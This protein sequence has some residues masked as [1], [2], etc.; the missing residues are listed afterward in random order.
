MTE[1]REKQHE[2]SRAYARLRH[3]KIL[4][5]LLLT[6]ALVVLAIAAIFLGTSDIHFSGLIAYLFPNWGA[7]HGIAPLTG[8]QIVIVLTLRLPRIISAVLVGAAMGICGTVMQS[9]TGNVMA[10]PFTTGISSAAGLGAAIGILFHPLGA[11]NTSVVVCAFGIAAINAAIVYG[12][13]AAGN[14]GAGGMILVGVA[15]NFLFSSA[16]SLLQY[17]ASEDQL[18]Q[19]VHWSFGSLTG[20][21]WTQIILM[22][23]TLGAAFVLFGKQAWSYNIMSSG[24]DESAKALGVNASRVRIASGVLV[25]IVSA[26]TISFVGVI[27][28]VGIVAPHVA[29]LL[30]GSEHRILLPAS[31]I[32]GAL[33][34]LAADSIGRTVISPV[35]IPVGVVLS[36]VGAPLFLYLIISR[37][38]RSSF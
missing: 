15:L 29:R 35:I 30:L 10:S 16:N 8:T 31:S 13:T 7:G 11:G 33:L 22:A 3:R 26:V 9:T 5:L 27:G 2:I 25:T 6:A 17:V 38:R 20:L 19:I 21:T 14:L 4:L 12:I 1:M 23:V 24:G 32:I 37:R 34:V 18:S 28:F 36:I